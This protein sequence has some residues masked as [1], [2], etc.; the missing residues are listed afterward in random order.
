MHSWVSHASRQDHSLSSHR[1]SQWWLNGSSDSP[2]VCEVTSQ[3][4][5]RRLMS[6]LR[7]WKAFSSLLRFLPTQGHVVLLL[8]GNSCFWTL[9][10]L[11]R[12]IK[13]PCDN[14]WNLSL[15]VHNDLVEFCDIIHTFVSWHSFSCH[16][17]TDNGGERS[18]S[19]PGIS[20]LDIYLSIFENIVESCSIFWHNDVIGVWVVFWVIE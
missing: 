18:W 2:L 16:D 13:E 12:S 7:A 20:H 3:I 5:M 17:V 15:I 11:C 19:Y 4:K 6:C 1:A 8:R 9:R 10:S 14:F